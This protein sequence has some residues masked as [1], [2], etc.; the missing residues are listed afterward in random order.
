MNAT[1]PGPRQDDIRANLFIAPFGSIGAVILADSL[2]RILAEGLDVGQL[3]WIGLAILTVV[4]GPLSVRLPLS[5][6]KVSFSDV[7]IFLSLLAFGPHLAIA[8]G[9]LDGF[10]ASTRRGGVWYK[11]GFNTSGL[12]ISV[13]LSSQVFPRLPADVRLHG[14]C[15]S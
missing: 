14:P 5:N 15:R 3:V 4:V 6:C 2:R 1:A 13:C 8:T 11:T 12:A 9:A 7:S 10:A